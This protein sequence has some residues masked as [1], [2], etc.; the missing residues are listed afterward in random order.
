MIVSDLYAGY[1]RS[2]NNKACAS[3]NHLPKS[4]THLRKDPA[5]SSE[6]DYIEKTSS[7]MFLKYLDGLKEFVDN[8]LLPYLESFRVSAERATAI[9]SRIWREKCSVET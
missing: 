8:Q 5:Y 2:T 4:L 1:I 3:L 6:L 7:M 9:D